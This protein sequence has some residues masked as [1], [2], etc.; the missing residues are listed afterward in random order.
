M[1]ENSPKEKLMTGA[2]QT[3]GSWLKPITSFSDIPSV[4]KDT[5]YGVLGTKV[6][7][8]HLVL[9]P[10]I[11]GQN[12]QSSEK[13]VFWL[14]DTLYFLENEAGKIDLTGFPKKDLG[15]LE[16]GKVL[17]YSW[18]KVAGRTTEGKSSTN[19][20]LYNT[21]THRHL[22]PFFNA[23]RSLYFYSHSY[24]SDLRAFRDIAHQSFKFFN[25]AKKSLK[26]NERVLA[27]IWQPE[28]TS[29]N[30]SVLQGSSNHLVVN[31]HLTILTELEL[32]FI[33]E[34]PDSL[35][36][37]GNRYSGIWHYVALENLLSVSVVETQSKGRFFDLSF[38]TKSD[39]S[40]R[41]SYSEENRPKALGLKEKLERLLKN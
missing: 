22:E 34:D 41:R 23:I 24:P 14:N 25:F 19:T 31:A 1:A 37:N 39:I 17:L 11:N 32:I 27:T 30:F 40:F 4:Y 6:N 29:R 21:A 26:G 20:I 16:V 3:M 15:Y 12:S 38:K 7:L 5:L 36:R 10:P 28:I 9:V 18:L 35:Q 2:R 33:E 13:L 8:P